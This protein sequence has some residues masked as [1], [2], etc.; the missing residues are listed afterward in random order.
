M[1]FAEIAVNRRV[2]GTFHYHIPDHLSGLIAP[3]HLVKVS[4]GTAHTTGIVVALHE[5]APIPQTKPVLERLDPVPVI[6]PAQL[7]LARWLARETLTPLG[8]CLWL[9]L[10]PGIAK[11]GDLVYTLVQEDAAD[12]SKTQARLVSLPAR[13]CAGGRS[14]TLRRVL[15]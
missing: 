12:L 3:G 8:L 9:M 10:P 11:R 13:C 1:M 2:Q 7:E 15:A 5:H 6:T 4:F 14:P